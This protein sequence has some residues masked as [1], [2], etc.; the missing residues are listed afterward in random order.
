MICDVILSH[1][2]A[3]TTGLGV[4]GVCKHVRWVYVKVWGVWDWDGDWDGIFR[5]TMIK[6]G[7]NCTECILFSL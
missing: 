2:I 5:I 6:N 1:L 3:D 4:G 7:S